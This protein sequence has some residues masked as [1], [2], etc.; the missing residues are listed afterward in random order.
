MRG[1]GVR[2]GAL[3]AKEIAEHLVERIARRI[4]RRLRLRLGRRRRWRGLGRDVDDDADQPPGQ[5]GE[6]IGKRHVGA[7][8]SWHC[9]SLRR[10]RLRCRRR[11]RGL[12]RSRCNRLSRAMWS[13]PAGRQA[14]L[15]I[16]VRGRRRRIALR[17]R[18]R[19]RR[20]RKSANEAA[21]TTP[22]RPKTLTP[23]PPRGARRGAAC[24]SGQRRRSSAG[25]SATVDMKW[26][27][28]W[29]GPIGQHDV[30]E[31][32]LWQDSAT[33]SAIRDVSARLVRRGAG[34][35]RPGAGRSRR[36][37]PAAGRRAAPSSSAPARRRR[38]WRA[39]SS[40][41]GRAALRRPG[42]HPARPCRPLRAHRDRRGQ[43]SG[44][45][46]GRCGGGARASS[47][48]RAGSG[49]TISWSA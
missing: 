12:V 44:A 25:L 1:P 29:Q 45:R 37:L 40:R 8:R 42:R 9:W 28:E 27:R 34:G 43:P 18:C 17:L 10:H 23:A 20:Q 7:G 16:A 36:H 33:V 2:R 30:R 3:V 38:R 39:R 11:R 24:G 14:G 49:P 41:P 31:I 26:H 15:S 35:G 48:W 4:L 5:L 6:H 13:L 46:P 22:R 19:R 47:T 21:T 32:R